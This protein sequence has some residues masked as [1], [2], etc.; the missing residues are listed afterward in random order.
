[1]FIGAI[2]S[3]ATTNFA[4]VLGITGTGLIA[5]PRKTIKS[6]GE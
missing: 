1:M 2:L 4:T 6:G 3:E 5:T